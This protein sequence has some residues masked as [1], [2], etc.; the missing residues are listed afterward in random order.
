MKKMRWLG[1]S[2][3]FRD[4]TRITSSSPRMWREIIESNQSAVIDSI[5]ILESKLKKLRQIIE[6]KDF[7]S[8]QDEFLKGK[9]LRDEWLKS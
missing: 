7:S 9:V 3:G 5:N 2:S 4:V 8:L 1:C 6:D